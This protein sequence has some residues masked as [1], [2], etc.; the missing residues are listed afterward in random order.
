MK[1]V[2]ILA[3]IF[4]PSIICSLHAQPVGIG[5]DALAC[6]L[7]KEL[8]STESNLFF[9]PL[10][11]GSAMALAYVG[12]S[13]TTR[14]QIQSAFGFPAENSLLG[15]WYRSIIGRMS[16]SSCEC[17]MANHLWLD[18]RWVIEPQ[19]LTAVSSLFG[20]SSSRLDFNHPSAVDTINR[21]VSEHTRNKIP[22]IIQQGS[23][24]SETPLVITNAIYFNGSWATAF[25][26]SRTEKDFFY[27]HNGDVA[28]VDMMSAPN[29]V[30]RYGTTAHAALVDMPFSDS[31][32][33][34]RLAL[35]HGS[36]DELVDQLC[37]DLLNEWNA[38]MAPIAIDLFVPKIS[39]KTHYG[40]NSALQSLGIIDAFD[41]QR[42]NFTGINNESQL[43]IDSVIHKASLDVT[44]EGAEAA[45]ATAIIIRCTC[46]SGVSDYYRPTFYANRPF[47]A[48]IIDTSTN[49]IL[50]IGVIQRP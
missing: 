5:L 40:L 37:P 49:S 45:A 35:P 12:S 24:S 29:R 16:S 13:G 10:S 39:L 17:T 9:S 32:M 33:I 1:I 11:I 47:L 20:S 4:I 2:R 8:Y 7:T 3:I 44:E 19:Y 50:F 25:D 6:R 28:T 43:W 22:S 42:A 15:E 21:W 46:S 34:M 27:S 41:P 14:D 36:I 30:L 18:T 26:Q 31:H 23:L 38:R 48:L